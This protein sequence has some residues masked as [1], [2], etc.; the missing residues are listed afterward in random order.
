VP[1]DPCSINIYQNAVMGGMRLVAYVAAMEVAPRPG[2]LAGT[3]RGPHGGVWC[4][5]TIFLQMLGFSSDAPGHSCLLPLRAGVVQESVTS[6]YESLRG[7]IS[8]PVGAR[9]EARFTLN[10]ANVTWCVR[11]LTLAWCTK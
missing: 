7:C 9:Y 5:V 8:G 2:F 11:A 4:H 1:Y 6:F 3:W 10:K